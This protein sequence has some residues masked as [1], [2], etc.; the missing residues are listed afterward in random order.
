M[1]NLLESIVHHYD[2]EKE[3]LV[4]ISVNYWYS[5]VYVGIRA[6][7]CVLRMKNIKVDCL[8][9]WRDFLVF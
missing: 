7:V 5:L 8:L 3:D 1:G 4:K 6:W 2:G 9:T